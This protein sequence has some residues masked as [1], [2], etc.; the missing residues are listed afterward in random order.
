LG[1]GEGLLRFSVGI[2]EIADLTGELRA[3]LD[4]V[5]ATMGP[6]SK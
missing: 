6:A 5:A 2:E 1:I 3:A 4:I